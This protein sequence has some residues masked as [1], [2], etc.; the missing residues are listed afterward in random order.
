MPKISKLFASVAMLLAP[1]SVAN[2]EQ[3]AGLTTDGKIVTFDSST[4]MT[5]AT[6]FAI[7][8]LTAGDSLI[9]I[10]LRPA[11]AIIYGVSQ[12]GRVY[13][14]TTS[15]I[16][17]LITTLSTIPTGTSFGIDF[18][19]VPDRLRIISETGQNLRANLAGG[20]TAVDTMISRS[21]GG[22]ISLQ[23]TAYTNS[24]PGGPAPATT[25][26]Y[27]IDSVTDALMT[28]AAPNGG[29][30]STVGALGVGL[31]NN[32]KVGFDISGATGIAYLNIDSAFYAVNLSTGAAT[33]ID[34][35][36][37][38]PLIGFTVNGAVPEPATWGMMIIGFGIVGSTMRRRNRRQPA[39]A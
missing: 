14:L 9:G 32:N 25:V 26:I 10:D 17:S 22:A 3:I 8:G 27:G 29:V 30:Y 24:V 20:A 39:V 6:S 38:G 19:P 34:T 16:A 36:G 21:G 18:N 5:I 37:S 28:S 12:T 13:S 15:G 33:F 4:P 35:I 11:N 7:T 23:G 2:A 31:T 1:I